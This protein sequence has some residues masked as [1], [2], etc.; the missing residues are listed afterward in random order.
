QHGQDRI[1]APR[2]PM[3]ERRMVIGGALAASVAG[4]AAM[5]ARPPL[6]LWPSW[7]ELTASV[8]T[9]PGEQRQVTLSDQVSIDL[10]TRSSLAVRSSEASEAQLIAGE[11]LI[12][13]PSQTQVPFTLVAGNGRTVAVGARFN[14]RLDERGVCVTCVAGSVRVEQGKST[15]SLGAGQQVR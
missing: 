14:V 11:A 15:A 8:R 1:T 13:S 4:G 2:S 12:T 9:Q 7:S 5:I 10:N 6:G 3:I